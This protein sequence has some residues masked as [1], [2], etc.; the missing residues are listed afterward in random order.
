MNIYNLIAGIITFV[1]IFPLGIWYWKSRYFNCLGCK[2]VIYK[3]D[4]IPYKIRRAYLCDECDE[5]LQGILQD[6]G[7][8]EK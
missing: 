2:K 4:S 3:K 1:V 7:R 5:E 8:G 6:Y